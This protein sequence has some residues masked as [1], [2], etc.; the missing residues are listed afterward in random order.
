MS[1]RATEYAESVAGGRVPACR[2]V[3]LACERHLRDL[4]D[5]RARGLRWDADAA[6]RVLSFCSAFLRLAG[7]RHEG[8]PFDPRPWQC[9][10]LGSLFG[11]KGDD[12]FRRFRT[13][14]VEIAK[15]NG[16]SPLA[17]AV[18]LYMLVADGEAR[19]EVYAA[20]TKKD[21]AMVLFRDAVAMR[22]QS[23]SI[24]RRVA[25]SGAA[26]KEWNLA[27]HA[28][29]SF[30]RPISSDD[31]QSGPRPHC[32]LIDEV[33]EHKT[34]HVVDMMRAGTKGRSQ[35][36]I[37]E[38]T[39]SG[40]DRASVCWRHHEYSLS[41]L[42]G[43]PNDSWFAF[44]CGLDPC[45]AHAAE[46]KTQP[47]EGCADCD[48]WRDERV[49][50]KANPNLDVSVTRKYLR[51]QV[52]EAEGMPSK[53]AV[54]KRLNFCWWTEGR[55]QWLT[56]ELWSRG[57]GPLDRAALSGRE[58]HGGLDVASTTDVAALVLA[59]R[60]AP[61][62]GLTALLP[63]FW[64]PEAT[65]DRRQ[66][67]DGIPWRAWAAAGLVTLT[68]GEVIDQDAIEG[69]VEAASEEYRLADVAFD[70]WNASQLCTHLQ[71]F[72]IVMV[73]FPQNVRNFNEPSKE[74]ERRLK[75][76]T[77]RH[78]SHPVLDWMA[79]NAVAETDRSGNLRPVKPSHNDPR[80]VDGVVAAVMALARLMLDPRGSGSV[81]DSEG[82]FYL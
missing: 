5:G 22:D 73:Q 37:V 2:T 69:A 14:Y 27:H 28:S 65:A 80:K 55:A 6:E 29:G 16:K 51:E 67:E 70:P 45:E 23:P 63:H 48:D 41:V 31:G 61:E 7:G 59:F 74:F 66:K 11:W 57:A 75:D 44:V 56:P 46:G 60:D 10:V 77:L 42:G 49:W 82:I 24:A 25:K 38:I 72:G 68:P 64:I 35:A 9:F 40:Y 19:A 13:A 4:A 12:G 78:G 43:L 1:D 52:A 53:Q 33:H 39:N 34:S 15:G 47:V 30:F 76:G 3:R 62:P 50:P 21:Q 17:A 32:G 79:G 20:A 58:C 71:Q 81:Y 54:V 18:G 8:R 26:G 36:L